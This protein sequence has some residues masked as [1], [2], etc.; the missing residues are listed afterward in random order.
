MSRPSVRRAIREVLPK[1]A[2]IAGAMSCATKDAAWSSSLRSEESPRGLAGLDPVNQ[3]RVDADNFSSDFLLALQ[4]WGAQH[5][6]ACLRDL[7]WWD[8]VEQFVHHEG[9]WFDLDYDACVCG[10]ARRNEA[11][12]LHTGCLL[13]GVGCTPW[14]WDLD[15]SS[16]TTYHHLG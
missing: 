16:V 14:L 12:G 3:D 8:P 9:E 7:H 2:T 1:V 11:S 13:H 5:N 4:H 10:G 15:R 6:L